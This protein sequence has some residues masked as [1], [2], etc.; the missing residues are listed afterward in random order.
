M[1]DQGHGILSSSFQAVSQHRYFPSATTSTSSNF[2][3]AAT[4]Y[5][6]LTP[7]QTQQSYLF[8]D[9]SEHP[10]LSPTH[11]AWWVGKT[12]RCRL[13]ILGAGATAGQIKA[14]NA[15]LKLNEVSIEIML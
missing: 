10:P 7:P 4:I 14:A 8:C 3:A 6:L 9:Y 11:T 5:L 13:L 15:E 1:Q 12:W 2:P